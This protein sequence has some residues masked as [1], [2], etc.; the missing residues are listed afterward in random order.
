MVFRS[1]LWE[2]LRS[3]PA[4]A[5]G[6]AGILLLLLP[7][8][9]APLICNGR[10]LFMIAPD[11]SWSMP[12][13]RF[14]FA[15]DCSEYLINQLFNFIALFL[16]FALLLHRRKIWL[17][18]LAL[19]LLIP[20][21][22]VSPRV[23]KTDYRK[24]TSAPGYRAFFAPV[25]Y[26][27]FEIVTDPCQGPSKKHWLGTDNVGRD[28][29][30]RLIYGARASLSVGI[31]STC[32]ALVIG[33]AVGLAAGFYR[34]W[35][36]LCVMRL[37]EILLCFP[38]FLLLLILMSLLGDYKFEQSIPVVILVIGMTGWIG[39]A[40]LVR[41]EVLKQCSLPYIASCLVVGIPARR[42]MFRH[43]LPNIVS[44]ILISFTFGVAGAI[45][46]ES[47][48]SFLG[49]GVQPPT[50]SWG[51]LLRQAFDN[52]LDYWHLTFFPGLA[53]FISI[54]SFNFSSYL[55]DRE[56]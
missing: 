52:P 28:V 53:L 10:P 3:R 31:L 16:P 39:L 13:L 56:K 51:E 42:I 29:A 12:F 25:P 26:G 30:A 46:A 41:G 32:L 5:A 1:G 7:A 27:P 11:G 49:F 48:L 4:A 18:I 38:T 55:F 22:P 37:V 44:P 15:P 50:P 24:L 17:V 33:T 54:L 6:F 34:G 9:Y 40:F 19:L 21:F 23:D 20:F 45:L 2:R 14:V 47:S 36:D 8:V 43:L 35:F